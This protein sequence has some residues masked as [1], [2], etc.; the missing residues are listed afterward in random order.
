MGQKP[1]D[2]QIRVQFS[3][4]YR[5]AGT[6]PVGQ[7]MARPLLPIIV[8]YCGST[9]FLVDSLPRYSLA[10]QTARGRRSGDYCQ[11]SV[12]SAEMLAR[13]IRFQH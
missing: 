2:T 13:K 5:A 4:L 1:V 12:D 11:H 3:S 7:A 8:K 6:G 10:S 9:A